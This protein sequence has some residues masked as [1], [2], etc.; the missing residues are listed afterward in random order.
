MPP[1][2]SKQVKLVKK[3]KK[4]VPVK[5]NLSPRR[6][7]E[8]KDEEIKQ[9]RAYA[10]KQQQ[11]LQAQVNRLEF[12]HQHHL[13]DIDR[14]TKE[15]EG[16]LED[17]D[18]Y[19]VGSC[20][21]ADELNKLV[22]TLKKEREEKASL[23]SKH[24]ILV[25]TFNDTAE[26]VENLQEELDEEKEEHRKDNALHQRDLRTIQEA[27]AEL[28]EKLNAEKEKNQNLHEYYDEVMG[29]TQENDEGT[30]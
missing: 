28:Q 11:E 25:E 20:K 24:K 15:R 16:I 7:I 19:R 10:G 22:E 6:I 26:W 2:K 14:L 3:S 21:R 1:K 18:K 9:L 5:K 8:Q 12:Q 13:A 23:E 30:D 17:L 29:A 4:A 27:L